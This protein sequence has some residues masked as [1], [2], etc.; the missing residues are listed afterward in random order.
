M[1]E[2]VPIPEHRLSSIPYSNHRGSN[3]QLWA[4]D[5]QPVPAYLYDQ[6]PIFCP[7]LLGTLTLPL[8]M[9][10]AMLPVNIGM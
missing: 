1:Q 8:K 7:V 4:D 9:V 3:G 10:R 6:K 2:A 5:G